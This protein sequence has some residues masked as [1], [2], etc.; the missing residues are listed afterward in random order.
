MI[1]RFYRKIFPDFYSLLLVKEL[2]D[3]KSILDL[4]CGKNSALQFVDAPYKVGVELFK[5]YLIESKKRRIHNKYILANVIKLKMKL[6]SFD[7]V[8]ALDVIE[9]LNKKDGLKLI[10]NMELWAKKK[11]VIFTPNGFLK[12]EEYDE[13][14]LQ[15][16]KSG[17]T[18]KEFR[19]LGFKVYGVNGLK[20]LRKE[21]GELRFKPK[22]FWLPI[23]ELSQ[24]ITFCL[25][26]LAFQLLVV[27]T[28]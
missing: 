18:V 24:K 8:V 13:N 16:H 7:A 5:P 9:H 28:I 2:K 23:S 10:K 11:V 21:G 3:C 26:K 12:Q 25:P 15:F 20:F 17:W 22:Y 14:V 4:G 6:K 27:K 19:E 1:K